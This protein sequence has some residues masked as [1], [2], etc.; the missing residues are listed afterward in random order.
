[1][2]LRDGVIKIR[3]RYARMKSIK[4]AE[5]KLTSSTDA[6]IRA[7][8]KKYDGAPSDLLKKLKKSKGMSSDE[9]ISSL[10]NVEN[11][12]TKKKANSKVKNIQTDGLN[13]EA[14]LKMVAPD[15]FACPEP[16]DPTKQATVIVMNS[17]KMVGCSLLDLKNLE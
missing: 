14:P 16:E 8:L 13:D 6:D 9:I 11:K 7:V 2:S 1:M 5:K 3:K 15:S 17:D 12:P 10:F 4:D